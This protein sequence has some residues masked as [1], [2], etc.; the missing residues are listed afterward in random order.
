MRLTRLLAVALCSMGFGAGIAPSAQAQWYVSGNVGAMIVNDS[1]V[2][3]S[4]G[5]ASANG[6]IEFDTGY[7]VSGAL[8]YT[9]GSIRAEAEVSY[10]KAD[11]DKI[12]GTATDGTTTV[13]GSG[14]ID[15]D[16]SALAFMVNGWY[17]FD[18]GSKWVPY[19][20]G[21]LGMAKVESTI[22][23]AESDDNVLAYQVGAGVGYKLTEN[24]TA[25]LGYKYFGTSD[26][27]FDGVDA[28]VGTHNFTVG[29]R[30]AF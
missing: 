9:F 11:M 24:T 20:G 13:S 7:G 8:G 3:G 29:V 25:T 4:Q 19:V 26:P 28:E 17:D 30:L 22:L 2:S 23:S 5:T 18:T 21:G 27:N 15:G 1:D 12:S 16:V 14:K 6:T 10:S